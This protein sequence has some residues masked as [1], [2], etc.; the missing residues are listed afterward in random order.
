MVSDY[1][2]DTF[3][4]LDEHFYP[5]PW[6]PKWPTAS[7]E[8][9]FSPMSKPLPSPLLSLSYLII[10]TSLYAASL[11]LMTKPLW[12]F[13]WASDL[14]WCVKWWPPRWQSRDAPGGRDPGPAHLPT[15]IYNIL[16]LGMPPLDQQ[17]FQRRER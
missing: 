14:Q 3:N 17:L 6:A 9:R 16:D 5:G 10:F 13:W 1:F 12:S 2:I 11:M 15:I 8:G 4:W 7:A